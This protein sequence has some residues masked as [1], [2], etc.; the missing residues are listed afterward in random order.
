MSGIKHGS[1][2]KRPVR[3][4]L[5]GGGGKHVSHPGGTATTSPTDIQRNLRPRT[6][7]SSLSHHRPKTTKKSNNHP[8]KRKYPKIAAHASRAHPPRRTPTSTNAPPPG[9]HHSPVS[10]RPDPTQRLHI[11]RKPKSQP[12]PFFSPYVILCRCPT[13]EQVCYNRDW[14]TNQPCPAVCGVLCFALPAGRTNTARSAHVSS[15][16]SCPPASQPVNKTRFY[17]PHQ[18]QTSSE[19][20]CNRAKV[21]SEQESVVEER[22]GGYIVSYLGTVAFCGLSGNRLRCC[23]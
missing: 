14:T 23:V 5:V 8:S 22:V 12:T 21:T 17:I 16:P 13:A 15:S 3:V 1:L 9:R 7:S 11:I 6:S 2:C 19:Y 18:Q 10:T 20:I 4:L